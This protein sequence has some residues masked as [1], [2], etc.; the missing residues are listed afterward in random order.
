MNITRYRHG[1]Q[2]TTSVQEETTD[3]NRDILNGNPSPSRKSDS[4]LSR[5]TEFLQLL[6]STTVASH[7]AEGYIISPTPG[8]DPEILGFATRNCVMLEANNK[9]LP[10]ER[11][12]NTNTL[13]VHC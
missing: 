8:E 4:H 6:T 12:G 9:Y 1:S 2:M 5:H 10:H 11:T 13:F 7:L 3:Y